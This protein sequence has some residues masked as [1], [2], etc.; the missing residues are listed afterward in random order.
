MAEGGANLL[1][2]AVLVT[3]FVALTCPFAHSFQQDASAR[4]SL[5]PCFTR[6]S[7]ITKEMNIPPPSLCCGMPGNSAPRLFCQSASWY[8]PAA[9]RSD[10][11]IH[12]LSCK[13]R[14]TRN[15]KRNSPMN[16][17]AKPMPRSIAKPRHSI[18]SRRG[19]R[20]ARLLG[21]EDLVCGFL[22]GRFAELSSSNEGF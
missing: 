15:R 18:R 5:T 20:G 9:D 16:T 10:Q 11:R 4:I 12:H 7:S 8:R 22:P 21:G 3:L 6:D 19:S 13:R 2:T 1:R 14:R 17:W